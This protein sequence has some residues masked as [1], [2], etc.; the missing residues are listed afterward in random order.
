MGLSHLRDNLS[1]H[2]A[3]AINLQNLQTE[4]IW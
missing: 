1:L 2:L 3:F 4:E